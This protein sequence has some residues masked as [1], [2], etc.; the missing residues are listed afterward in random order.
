MKFLFAH[1]YF[2]EKCAWLSEGNFTL[3]PELFKKSVLGYMEGY[4]KFCLRPSTFPKN[5][6]WYSR[7]IF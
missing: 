1:K 7:E 2:R 6:A 4:K 5:C 3:D